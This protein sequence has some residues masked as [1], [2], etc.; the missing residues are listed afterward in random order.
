MAVLIGGDTVTNKFEITKRQEQILKLIVE[1]HIKTAKAISS[2]SLCDV[3]NCS[4]ATIRNEM[5]ILEDLGLIAKEHISSGRIPS[6]RGYRYYVDNI[7]QPRELTGEDML[8]LQTIFHNQSLMLSDVIVKSMEIISELTNYTSIV[9]GSSSQDNRLSKVDAV[10]IN[11]NRIIAIVI[12]DKGHVE[13]KNI[14]IDSSISIAEVQK[15]IDL[16][17]KLIVGTPICEISEKLEYEI[18]PIISRYVTQY[19]ALYNAFYNAFSDF[20]KE[21]KIRITGASNILKQ[22]EFKDA[23]KIAEILQKFD[24]RDFIRNIMQEGNGISIYVGSESDFDQDVGLIKTS[25]EVDGEV[26]TIAIIGPKRME[27]DRVLA[28]LEYVKKNIGG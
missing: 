6:E 12:T 13:H 5:A 15:T 21:T 11:E 28:L 18:K 14:Y 26:G 27:Y 10:P 19:E 3:L 25:F 16:I 1:E 9:L 17:N 4:S 23:N 22:P 8:K 2:K 20:S 24:D 7:M